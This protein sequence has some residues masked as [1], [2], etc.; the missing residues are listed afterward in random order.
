MA[1]DLHSEGLRADNVDVAL[2]AQDEPA[3]RP[4][5]VPPPPAPFA[6]EHPTDPPLVATGSALHEILDN[7]SLQKGWHDLENGDKAT[8]SV[9]R[10]NF[11]TCVPT[12]DVKDH[13]AIGNI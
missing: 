12:Y 8:V 5:P 1:P 4:T 9:R 13:R 6:F 11:Q 7:I 10:K 2:G 3:S